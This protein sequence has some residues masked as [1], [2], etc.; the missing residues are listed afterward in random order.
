MH[1]IILNEGNWYCDLFVTESVKREVFAIFY[2]VRQTLKL[3]LCL[4]IV[5]KH[6]SMEMYGGVEVYMQTFLTSALD[7]GE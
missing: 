4:K 7:G 5:I 1:A 6:Y 3:S 2:D